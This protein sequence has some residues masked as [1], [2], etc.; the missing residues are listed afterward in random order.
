MNTRFVSRSRSGSE[1]IWLR[2]SAA[3]SDC[4]SPWRPVAQKRHPMRHP[5]CEETQSVAAR[6]REW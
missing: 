3:E 2:I 6:R 5:A 4:W 1:T